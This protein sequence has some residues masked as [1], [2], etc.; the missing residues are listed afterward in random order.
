MSLPLRKRTVHFYEIHLSSYT[1]A[2]VKNPSCASLTDL[3]N[4]FALLASGSTLPRTI[5]KSSQ[6]HTVLAD[7][8][9]DPASNC[10]ELLISKAN[11]ALSDVAL[12]DMGTAKLRKAGKT[13]L[14]GIEVS[15]H[16]LIRPNADGKRAAC[17]LTM[18]A[19]VSAKDIEVLLRLLSRQA[20]KA[21]DSRS[22]AL[23][24]FDDPSGAKG[25]DGMPLQYK[26]QYGFAA[27]GHQGQTLATAL[28]TGEFESMELIAHEQEKFDAGGN[29]EIVERSIGI[30]AKLP[31]TVTGASIRNAIRSYQQS[32]DGALYDKLRLHY[33]TV[34]G[35]RTSAVLEI[36]NLD[37]AFTLKE[38]IEFESDVEAQQEKLSA[39]ILAGM[40]PLLQLVP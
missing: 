12:R 11:A 23:F 2:A 33:K 22:K 37:A 1:K 17:L 35:K 40:K 19:G 3:L 13:K 10:Y 29:L 20:S 7:W 5:R 16:V 24:Y 21:K 30:Q 26:V 32:P 39:V 38:H 27:F 6:L 28:Q 15:A 8:R 25:P 34:A 31:K 14:E 18:G 4:N 36:K 9:Y